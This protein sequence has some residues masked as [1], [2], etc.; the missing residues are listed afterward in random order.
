MIE[1]YIAISLISYLL[2]S[3]PFALVINKLFF[4]QDIRT[5]GSKNTGA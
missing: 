1:K 5:F 2:G 4:K 3:I